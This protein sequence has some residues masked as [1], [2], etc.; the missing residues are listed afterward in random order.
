MFATLIAKKLDL[1][2]TTFVP[3]TIISIKVVNKKFAIFLI[4]I[5]LPLKYILCI[6][7]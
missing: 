3:M 4:N 1:V 2:L 6:Y 7:Y 5:F